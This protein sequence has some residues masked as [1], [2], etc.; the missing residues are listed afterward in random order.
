MLNR[1]DDVCESL[2][3]FLPDCFGGF[4]FV[5]CHDNEIANQGADVDCDVAFSWIFFHVFLTFAELF[6]LKF[7]SYGF[8]TC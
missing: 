8:K 6:N 3:D 1:F 2:R 7:Y 4:A 5:V